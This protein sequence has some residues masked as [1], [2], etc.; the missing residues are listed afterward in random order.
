MGREKRRS[1]RRRR[2]KEWRREREGKEDEG[3]NVEWEE[4][5][6][7]RGGEACRG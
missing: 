2:T 4:R 7:M 1:R 3:G 6:R 5:K